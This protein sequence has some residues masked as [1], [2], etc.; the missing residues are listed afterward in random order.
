M[1]QLGAIRVDDATVE[2]R[3]WAPHADSPA[4]RIGGDE[5]VLAAEEDGAFS[6]RAPARAGDDYVF[7]L[8]GKELPDPCSRFQPEG[9]RGPSRVVDT[10]RFEIAAGPDVRLEELVLYELHVGTFSP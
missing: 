2:F 8:G 9:V 10:A 4:V 7:V 1:R 3:V 6:A 5:H